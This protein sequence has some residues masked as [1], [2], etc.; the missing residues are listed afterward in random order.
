MRLAICVAAMAV[1]GSAQETRFDTAAVKAV[2]LSRPGGYRHTMNAGGVSMSGVSLGY[3]IRLAYGIPLQRWYELAGPEWLN[4][5]TGVLVEIVA[6]TDTP[7]SE[8]RIKLMLQT[9]LRERFRMESHREMREVPA[10]DLV[11][12]GKKDG[13][14]RAAPGG[15]MKMKNGNGREWIFQSF[16]MGQLA[17]QLGHPI[18]TRPVVNKTGLTGAFDFTLD[19]GPYVIDPATGQLIVDA[20]GRVDTESAMMRALKDQLGLELKGS[21]IPVSVLV[22][23]RLDKTPTGN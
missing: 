17:T 7:A 16:T 3:V 10:W 8:D 5:P 19:E 9:L 11:M 22:V 15:E 20:I 4:P 21:H 1:C 6:K 12:S 13:L 14:K 18:T 23:D 2:D